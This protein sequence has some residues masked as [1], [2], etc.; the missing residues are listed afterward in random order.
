MLEQN[1][2]I[3]LK[4]NIF[5]YGVFLLLIV[6]NSNIPPIEAVPGLALI[7][8][9]IGLISLP[10]LLL[11]ISFLFCVFYAVRFSNSFSIV[12]A[13]IAI[14][15]LMCVMIINFDQLYRLSYF[16]LI[17]VG[18]YLVGRILGYFSDEKLIINSL[19]IG[20][21]IQVCLVFYSIFISPLNFETSI[22]RDLFRDMNSHIEGY[23][24]RAVGSIGHPVVLGAILIPSFIC[25]LNDFLFCQNKLKKII[26][27]IC[28]ILT[29]AAIFLTFSRGTW[30]TIALVVFYLVIK[31]KLLKRVKTWFVFMFFAIYLMYSSYGELLLERI[32]MLS[33]TSS[34]SVSHRLY[35][36]FWTFEQVCKN[37]GTFLWGSGVGSKNSLL[38]ENPPPDNFLVID[39]TYLSLLTE[40]GLIGI[41]LLLFTL[42][43]AIYGYD[44]EISLIGFIVI[45]LSI[46]GM[47]F[48]LY[49]WEQISIIFWILVG[50][51]IS[52]HSKKSLKY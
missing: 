21:M 33:D 4:R 17:I 11:I 32:F 48:D 7:D 42:F 2:K 25:W 13:D 35:M 52:E 10:R 19:K 45:A 39:N 18:G 8:T 38:M 34:G 3:N 31:K 51:C 40:T 30:L 44:K 47:T 26:S 14:Y 37:V 6:I 22:G 24:I 20:G 1:Y 23:N 29:S 9:P 41:I 12:T 36:Y 15:F 50:F 16:I 46:N 28:L 27:G 49:Y 5:L 43:K